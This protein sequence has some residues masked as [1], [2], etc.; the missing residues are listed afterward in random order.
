MATIDWLSPDKMT[1][2]WL[3]ALPLAVTIIGLDQLSKHLILGEPAFNALACL[4]DNA[5]GRI[6]L[7]PVFDLSMTWNRG[8]SFGALQAEGAARWVLF[9][10]T[11]AIAIGFT[12]WLLRAE[13]WLTALSLALV[14]G[15]AVGNL[16]DRAR[17]GAVVDFLDFSGMFFPWIFNVADAS[18]SVGAAI[19]LL[20]QVLAGRKAPG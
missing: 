5:C 2:H 6:E 16:V 12:V 8:V 20:D 14:I 19:L 13:R 10:L 7:S 4:A 3:W 15:G 9:A 17:F 1:R 18:I 11:S